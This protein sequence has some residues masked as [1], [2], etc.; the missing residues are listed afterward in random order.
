L[1]LMRLLRQYLLSHG[2]RP[3]SIICHPGSPYRQL[4]EMQDTLGF[5]NLIEGHISCLYLNMIQWDI[6]CRKLGK[7][8]PH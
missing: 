4:A 3:M 6:D 1:P 2:F 8:A 5:Q 7:R